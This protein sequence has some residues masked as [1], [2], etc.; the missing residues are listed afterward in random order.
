M[1]PSPGSGQIWFGSGQGQ[2]RSL[3]LFSSKIPGEK[4]AAE[5]E[6]VPFGDPEKPSVVMNRGGLNLS[7]HIS[8]TP[9]Q[10]K[11][12]NKMTRN[13][14]SYAGLPSVPGRVRGIPTSWK[15]ARRAPTPH[16]T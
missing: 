10:S 2:D 3:G 12:R 16:P 9:E 14:A 13:K 11:H 7:M 4:P 6:V 8:P 1:L 5:T 15:T